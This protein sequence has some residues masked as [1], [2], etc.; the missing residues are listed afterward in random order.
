MFGQGLF[1]Y[2]STNAGIKAQLGSPRADKETGVFPVLAP[3]GSTFPYITVTQISGVP[4]ESM[5][6]Q[7]R[8][9]TARIR[10]SCFGSSYGQAKTLAEAVRQAF[11]SSSQFQVTLSDGTVLQNASPVPP[12]EVDDVESAG[13]GRI[14]STH[15]DYEFMYTNVS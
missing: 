12:T 5:Q 1:T 11:G 9:T 13:H 14:Y 15:L 6:A 2:L 7:N 10:F 4:V 3:E 8:L